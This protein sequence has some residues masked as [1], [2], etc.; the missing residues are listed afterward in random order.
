MARPGNS[1]DRGAR[2]FEGGC[3]DHVLGISHWHAERIGCAPL[4]RYPTYG[5]R[6]AFGAGRIDGTVREGSAPTRYG[7]VLDDF[8]MRPA[9]GRG[10][11]ALSLTASRDL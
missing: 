10:C 6:A 7:D 3:G 1:L 5:N 4:H 8:G 11:R 9:R 2:G